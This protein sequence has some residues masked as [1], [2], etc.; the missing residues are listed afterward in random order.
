MGDVRPLR[1]PCGLCLYIA[2]HFR[3]S[4]V[5]YVLSEVGVY[6]YVSTCTCVVLGCIENPFPSMLIELVAIASPHEKGC[7]NYIAL[8]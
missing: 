3:T 5:V 6:W 2:S 7:S 4:L 8:V 1:C